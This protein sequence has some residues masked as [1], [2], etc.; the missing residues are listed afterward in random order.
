MAG[1]NPSLDERV[2]QLARQL[3][4]LSRRIDFLY[5]SLGAV[6]LDAEAGS[7]PGRSVGPADEEIIQWADRASLLPR[8]STLCFLLVAALVLRTVTDNEIVD[9]RVGSIIGM[10]Y[11]ALLMLLGW[12]QYRRASRLAPVFAVCG[13][14]FMCAIVLETHERFR[15]LPTIPAYALLGA[16][17]AGMAAMTHRFRAPLPI[18]AGSLGMC[19]ASAAIDYP[20]PFF[21]FPALILLTANA[22][23][24]LA[25][26]V[27]RCAWLRW[28]ILAITLFILTLWSTKIAISL[29]RG[30]SLSASLAFGWFF[31]VLASF[32]VFYPAISLLAI[33]RGGAERPSPFDV[34]LP[35]VSGGVCFLAAYQVVAAG[36]EGA[37]ILGLMAFFLALAHFGVAG[38][39]AAR[40]LR[41][42]PGTNAFALAGSTLLALGLPQILGSLMHALPVLSAAALGLICLSDRWQSGG[43]RATANL[44]QLGVG[45]SLLVVAGGS[46]GRA[47]L[48]IA[49]AVTA[50]VSGIL[51]V[52]HH[53]WSRSHDPPRGSVFFSRWDRADRSATMVLI[54]SLLSAFLALKA[55]LHGGLGLFAPPLENTL[56]CAQTVL[57]NLSAGGLMLYA[58]LTVNKEMRNIAILVTAVGALGVL[59]DLVHAR[60]LPLVL[61][62]LSFGLLVLLE[63]VAI[64]RWRNRPGPGDGSADHPRIGAHG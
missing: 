28:I 42:A 17:G 1:E 16:T 34:A 30:E 58:C 18:L 56:R 63:S 9:V 64:R 19:V 6:D 45:V 15:T 40:R 36:N 47:D 25:A 20:N 53:G 2:E 29:A 54:G 14:L 50:G 4:R 12:R 38:A 32:E 10:G 8:L 62:V 13:A 35:T 41:G 27:Q 61:S 52:L 55:G 24:H 26:R 23:G 44:L 31:P 51:G 33:L 43:V 46:G 39:L 57:I 59:G 3:D 21:L 49:G 5:S 7:R 37:T 48:S 60:G 11:A 22:F